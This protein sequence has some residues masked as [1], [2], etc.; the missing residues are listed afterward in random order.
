MDPCLFGT[1]AQIEEDEEQIFVSIKDNKKEMKK[2][3]KSI[4]TARFPP[5]DYLSVQW[6]ENMGTNVTVI[7]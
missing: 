6:T 2:I 4:V 3:T 1:Q 7:F 5:T